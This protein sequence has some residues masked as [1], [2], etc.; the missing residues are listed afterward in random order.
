[1][2]S[3]RTIVVSM[4]AV[5][6]V[7]ASAVPAAAQDPAAQKQ[8]SK[9]SFEVT[10]YPILVVA[11]VFGASVDL[12]PLPPGGGGGGGGGGTGGESGDVNQSTDLSLNAA[13][14]AGF[15]LRADRW[16]GEMRGQWA[17]VSADRQ[18]PRVNVKTEAYFFYGRAGVR[19]IDGFSATGGF[20]RVRVNLS[21]TL[22]PPSLD[23]TIS[24]SADTVL[25]DPMVGVEWRHRAGRWTISGNF[26]GGGF[27]VGTDS[28]IVGEARANWRFMKHTELRL[29]Y[30]YFYYKYTVANVSI[31][32]FQRQLVSSQSL[33][34]PE[35]GIGIVF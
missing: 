28:D 12:P 27:G 30:T 14:M 20:R 16:F 33:N 6:A 19:L 35:L 34:G 4:I 18:L 10:I 23:H 29:G 21:A 25:W 24:G 5:A 1:M 22:S 13:Y 2:N 15:E 3:R 8:E 9:Q 26:E 32:S 7:C 11:P 31:G 17:S